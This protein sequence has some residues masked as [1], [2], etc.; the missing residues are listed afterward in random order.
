M[1][2]EEEPVANDITNYITGDTSTD[3][4]ITSKHETPR[5]GWQIGLCLEWGMFIIN[6]WFVKSI[7]DQLCRAVGN[8]S[9]LNLHMVALVPQC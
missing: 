4:V 2:K 7:S 8:H 1:E 9:R 5:E 3:S 6:Y